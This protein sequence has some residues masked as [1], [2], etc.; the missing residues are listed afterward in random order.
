ML[1]A[2]TTP[3]RVS[4]KHS[5]DISISPTPEVI[6][7]PCVAEQ[8]LFDDSVYEGKG[9]VAVAAYNGRTRAMR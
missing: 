3:N 6:T 2:G 9:T 5:D 7:I 8:R 4:D 1:T